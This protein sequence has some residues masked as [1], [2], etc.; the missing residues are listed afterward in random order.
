MELQ[1]LSVFY[2]VARRGSFSGASAYLRVSQPSLSRTVQNLEASLNAKLFIRQAR[3]VSLTQEGQRVY[4]R[5]HR[6]FQECEAIEKKTSERSPHLRI[7]ASENLCI[8]LIPKILARNTKSLTVQSLD[9]ISGTS[10]E[11]VK[12]VLND[13][14]DI[15]YC[16]H[17]SKLPGLLSVVVASVEFWLVVSPRLVGRKASL[18]DLKNAAFIGSISKKYSGTYAAKSLLSELNLSPSETKYQSNSQEAQLSM[19]E[20][21]L[22]YSLVPWFIAQDRIK[23]GVLKA[24]PTPR[25]LK[26][27]LYRLKKLDSPATF[28][29]NFE[30]SLKTE[31][32]FS[33]GCGLKDSQ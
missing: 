1:H 15:G 20:A 22:G 2:E 31:V 27:P 29:E 5:C 13:E 25:A 23:S 26:T 16:Y 7:A 19:V 33:G 10:E 30:Q 11:I 32:L 28:Y 6:I 9:L 18:K 21:G 8:H 4:E 3:G 24:V 14:A 17:P 12:S